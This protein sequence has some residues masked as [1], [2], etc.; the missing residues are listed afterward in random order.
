MKK[1]KDISIQIFRILAAGGVLLVHFNYRFD[2]SGYLGK[3]LSLGKFGL[4]VFF[5]L[6]GYLATF[7]DGNNVKKWIKKRIWR[8]VPVYYIILTFY[9]IWHSW[10]VKDVPSDNFGL[11][12]YRYYLGLNALL[13][14]N[15]IFWKGIH[16]IWYVSVV[17]I[18]YLIHAICWRYLCEK[19]IFFWIKIFILLSFGALT[20]DLVDPLA[21]VNFF[22]FLQYF[23]L[24]IIVSKVDNKRNIIGILVLLILPTIFFILGDHWLAMNLFFAIGFSAVLAMTKN[25]WV[26]YP[27]DFIKNVIN[28]LD[29]ITYC[30]FLVH[31]IVID[32]LSVYTISIGIAKSLQI[33]IFVFSTIILIIL[34]RIIEKLIQR[35][36]FNWIK[37]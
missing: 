34:L 25:R 14:S 15:D 6:S 31:P 10:I 28:K 36:L 17:W 12:W 27:N 24:G 5:I 22:A 26:T 35:E 4:Y 30:I 1:E 37:L 7:W 13:P 20:L 3:I 23:V 11:G 29:S 32:L 18:F 33:L 2:I 16:A 21:T 9:M 8:L 19:K